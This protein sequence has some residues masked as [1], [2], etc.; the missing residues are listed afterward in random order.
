MCEVPRSKVYNNESEQRW[1]LV[2]SPLARRVLEAVYKEIPQ[3]QAAL[4]LNQL[5]RVPPF[6]TPGGVTIRE[7]L[8]RSGIAQAIASGNEFIPDIYEYLPLIWRYPAKLLRPRTQTQ[9][10]VHVLRNLRWYLAPP[11]RIAIP[12][13]MLASLLAALLLIVALSTLIALA[14]PGSGGYIFG[15]L[16]LILWLFKSGELLLT[17]FSAP[18]SRNLLYDDAAVEYFLYLLESYSDG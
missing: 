9:L 11:Q 3:A 1:P 16:L 2:S 18:A 12:F 7:R 8:R 13:G 6:I 14:E 4:P 17:K 5:R 15:A 10:A